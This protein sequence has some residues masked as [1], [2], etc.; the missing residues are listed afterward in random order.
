MMKQ[1][2]L[3]ALIN[4][5]FISVLIV[6]I[7]GCSSGSSSPEPGTNQSST[8][9][10]A[11]TL[12]LNAQPGPIITI[13]V[14]ETAIL[15]G[16]YS[17]ASSNESL[18]YEW[19]FSSIPDGSNAQLQNSTTMNPS[20]IAD[21]KGTYRV[22]LVVSASGV[23]SQRTVAIVQAGEPTGPVIHQNFSSNC[24]NCH[25]GDY[26]VVGTKVADHLATSNLC[27]ACHSTFD[28]AA[29]SFIDHQ[30][31]FGNCSECHNGIKAVGKSVFHEVTDGECSDCHNTSS[32]LELAADGTYDHSNLSRLCTACHNGTVATGKTASVL[33]GG[34]HP[35]TDHECGYCHTTTSFQGAYPDHTGPS[36]TG[37]GITCDSC[38]VA[39]GTGSARGQSVGHPLT[40][41]DCDT[42]H[43]I[44][45]F[46]MTDGIFNHSV[47]D[48][49]VQSC[50]SCH[51]DST[52]INAR[53]K[54]SAIPD[55]PAT[56][57]DCGACHNTESFSPAFGVDHTDPA[58]LAQ[59]CDNC[60][61]G[62]DATGIPLTTPFYEHMPI[63]TEDC[64]ACHTPGTFSTGTYNHA[65]VVNGCTACHN[66]VISVGKLENHIPTN[67][68]NQ[69]CAACHNTTDFAQATFSHVGISGN[70]VSCHDGNISSGKALNHLPTDQDCSTCHTTATIGSSTAPFKDTPNFVHAGITGNCESCHSGNPVYVATGAIGKGSNHIPAQNECFVCHKDTTTGGFVSSSIFLS[71]VHIDLTQGCEGCHSS[72]YLPTAGGNPNV[73]KAVTHLPTN[74]DCDVCHTNNSFTP[75]IFAHTGI[76]GNCASC[77]DG[78]A[79]NVAAGA[80]GTNP[81]HPATNGQDCGVCHSISTTF[82]DAVF[83]HTGRVDNCAECHGD[84]ASGATTKKNI[85]HVPTTEDCSLCHVPGTFATAVFDHT[86]IVD[87][88]VSCH[89]GSGAIATVKDSN[90]LPTTE[91]CSVCHNTTAFAGARFDHQGIIDNCASC[92]DGIVAIGKAPT[93]NH[94]P[95][96]ED[97][98]VCH[99]TTGF[100]PATFNHVGITDN[101][102]SCHG[103]GFATGKSDG[104]VVTNQDCGVCH[105]T[106]SFIPATFDHT[107]IV[108]NCESCHGVTA[109]GKDANH[110]AT[111][112]DCHYCHTTAT[113]VGGTWTHDAS[114]AGNCDSC[115]NKTGGG[116]TGKPSGHINTTVQ[117]DECHS[118]STWT[119]DIFKHSSSGDYPG[120][121]RRDPGCTGCHGSTISSNIPWPSSRYAPY[122]AACHASDFRS[123]SKHIGGRSGTIEQNK[124]CGGSGCHRVTS[125]SF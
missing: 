69:D 119:P 51:N 94:V 8:S 25:S 42:C 6:I 20:F 58:V 45:S 4:Y 65:G 2:P 112:L 11:S 107:G 114:S 76:T 30:E 62:V 86:G 32:F 57:S 104:H 75:S 123:E 110:V 100:I 70:C 37:P 5:L 77:H 33:E 97:C 16:G 54:S 60:H 12:I 48:P 103:A 91:D 101:C 21:V 98:S 27:Q 63:T 53:S 34:S 47:I 108:D 38:H 117:C 55:H 82:A 40:I 87:N 120:D 50:E 106:S 115:H 95:T 67:P 41:V 64:A 44:I 79:N 90:H 18:S 88:C 26:V 24:T 35:E 93:P 85:G 116:A 31:V 19:S 102:S 46:K 122:C 92:H 68:D 1:G 3:H 96:N 72:P 111:S 15:N 118:T 7:A 99:Q 81:G 52:S 29:T 23:T 14:G 78:S 121:H 125:S 83:D 113:F 105:N 124:N 22:Q 89:A 43:S 10:S 17:S 39:D 73:V 49:A 56:N 80:L 66:N 109:K 61:N 13:G 84:G 9:T 36:V 59:R 71:N 74:Q 28:F